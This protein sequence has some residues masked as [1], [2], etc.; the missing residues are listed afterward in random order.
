MIDISRAATRATEIIHRMRRM[1]SGGEPE[2]AELNLNQLVRDVVELLGD[3]ALRQRVR[4]DYD[5]DPREPTAF[6]DPIQLQQVLINLLNNA[7]EATVNALPAERT[8]TVTTRQVDG[9]LELRV[10]DHG[11]SLEPAALSRLFEPLYTTKRSGMGLGLYITRAIV[12]SHGGHIS[13]LRTDHD[14]GLTMR[15]RFPVIPHL[16]FQQIVRSSNS[17]WANV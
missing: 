16:P 11:P 10:S 17:D 2:R 13:A 7:I 9:H 15:V 4:L 3:D 6:G 5:L 12:E 8:V 14:H 1:F